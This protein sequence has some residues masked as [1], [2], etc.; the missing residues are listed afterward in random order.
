MPGWSYLAVLTF[1]LLSA[2]AQNSTG[3]NSTGS[4]LNFGPVNFASYNN[5]VYRDNVTSCQILLSE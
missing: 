1:G 2:Y 4:N 3:G 5:Y